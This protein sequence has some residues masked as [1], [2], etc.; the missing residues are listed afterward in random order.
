M[1]HSSAILLRSSCPI[2]EGFVA[3]DSVGAE[4][5][6]VLGFVVVKDEPVTAPETS[7]RVGC[8]GLG[9]VAL[10]VS[11]TV[12]FSR[13]VVQKCEQIAAA[14]VFVARQYGGVVG[15]QGGQ[16]LLLRRT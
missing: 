15:L 11:G 2:R 8:G 5:P 16:I 9:W 7:D 6:L 14:K 1:S 3:G 10:V 13:K 12:E 4:K